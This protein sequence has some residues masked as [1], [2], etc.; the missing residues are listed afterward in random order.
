ML[1]SHAFK[2]LRLSTQRVSVGDTVS[3]VTLATNALDIT[4][5]IDNRGNTDVLIEIG[6]IDPSDTTSYPIP[7]MTSQPIGLGQERE[8]RLK[9]PAG[10]TSAEVIVTPGEGL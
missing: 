4:V 6:A 7:A 3:T 8:L 2:P 9:R 5:W 1:A 10:S